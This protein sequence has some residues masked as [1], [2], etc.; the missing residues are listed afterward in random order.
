MKINKLILS[1]IIALGGAF[2]ANAQN[3]AVEETENVFQPHWYIMGQVGGQ[4]TL[5]ETSFGRLASF[6]A[7]IGVGYRFNSVLGVR[8]IANGWTSKGSITVSRI[9][10]PGRRLRCAERWWCRRAPARVW[11]YRPRR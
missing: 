3:V 10:R 1:A 8:V 4:E 5:G 6:N 11:R 2:S 7:Q 9:S